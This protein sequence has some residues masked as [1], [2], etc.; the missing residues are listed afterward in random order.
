MNCLIQAQ[1]AGKLKQD[2]QN[3]IQEANYF[4][5]IAKR[6]AKGVNYLNFKNQIINFLFLFFFK[7]RFC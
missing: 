4:I 5:G 1:L 6:L 3:F 2:Q 7:K